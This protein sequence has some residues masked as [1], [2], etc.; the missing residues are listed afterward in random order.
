MK[1]YAIG[2]IL[3][4]FSFGVMA[5]GVTGGLFFSPV[6]SWLKPDSKNITKS[7]SRFG[8]GFGVPVDFNFSKNFAFSTG[9]S[10]TNLGGSLKYADSISNFKTVDTTFTRLNPNTV[11]KYKTS[12]IEIPLSFKG[13]TNEIGYITYFLKVGIS[14]QFRFKAKGDI[15]VNEGDNVDI[16]DEVRAFNMGYHIGGGIEYSLGGSTKLLVEAVFTNGLTNFSKVETLNKGT[17]KNE[18]TIMNS[19]ALKVGILF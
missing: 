6:V 9:I 17:L 14:P 18:K 1:K 3:V 5:Q 10:Y 8:F 19:I 4:M 7:S 13:K 2:I 12:F 16:K 15:T 11:V